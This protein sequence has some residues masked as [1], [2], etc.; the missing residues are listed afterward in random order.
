MEVNVMSKLT[1]PLKG[2]HG[3]V[4]N[5]AHTY[6]DVDMRGLVTC[7]TLYIHV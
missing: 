6:Q 2:A 3:W 7:H 4:S 5:H 1:T